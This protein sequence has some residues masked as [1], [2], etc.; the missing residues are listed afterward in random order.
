VRLSAVAA[1]VLVI[2]AI[3][4]G[5]AGD[6]TARSRAALKGLATDERVGW[7]AEHRGALQWTVVGI[8]ALVLVFWN[9]PT[10]AVVLLDAAF[11]LAAISVIGALASAGSQAG[12][13]ATS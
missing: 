7:V 3:L 11:V 9:P 6:I 13:G 5:R 12:T 10:L 4:I 8:G 1:I 2:I